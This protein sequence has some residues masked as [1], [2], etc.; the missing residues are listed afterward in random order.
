MKSFVIVSLKGLN[1]VEFPLE[2]ISVCLHRLIHYSLQYVVCLPSEGMFGFIS[3]DKHLSGWPV[4][5][6]EAELE[7]K[8]KSIIR[9]CRL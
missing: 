1:C 8:E 2:P 7:K 5:A 6:F 3:E 4:L 9:C